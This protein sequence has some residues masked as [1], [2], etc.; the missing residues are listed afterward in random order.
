MDRAQF[1]RFRVRVDEAARHACHALLALDALRT[2]DDPEER[3]AYSDVHDLIADL[4]SLRVELDR[5][6]EPVDD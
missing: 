5:W 4:S 3:A 1:D 6:P 2:S